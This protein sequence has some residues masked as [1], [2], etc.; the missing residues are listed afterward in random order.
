MEI[1]VG[2]SQITNPWNAHILVDFNLRKNFK[3]SKNYAF[4]LPFGH[5]IVS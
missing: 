4:F 2:Y 1:Q 3:K 5:F